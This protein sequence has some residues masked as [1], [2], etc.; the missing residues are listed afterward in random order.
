MMAADG[1]SCANPTNAKRTVRTVLIVGADL[2]AP[3]TA[4]WDFDPCRC[5]NVSFQARRRE[6]KTAILSEIPK[7][8]TRNKPFLP[9]TA[10]RLRFC[11]WALLPM[12]LIIP[13]VCG[14]KLEDGGQV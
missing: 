8:R 5:Q 14:R 7:V 10:G 13:G 2:G 1:R 11:D 6:T 4:C 9:N 3:T 12:F